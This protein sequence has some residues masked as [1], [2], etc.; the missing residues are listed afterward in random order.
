MPRMGLCSRVLFAGLCVLP[1]GLMAACGGPDFTSGAAPPPSKAAEGGSDR[2]DTPIIL[3]NPVSSQTGDDGGDAAVDGTR[4][5]ATAD[6][7]PVEDATIAL[8]PGDATASTA[9]ADGGKAANADAKNG[10][11][12]DGIAA[13]TA[14]AGCPVG[15]ASCDGGC[16]QLASDPHHCGAC[17][18]DCSRLPNVGSAGLACGAGHCVYQCATDYADCADSGTGC[19]SSLLSVSHCGACGSSCGTTAPAC[20]PTDA[21]SYACTL[22]CPSP[23]T[24]CSGTCADLASDPKNCGGCGMACSPG[25]R[26]SG[27]HC[28]C[29][30]TSGCN[31]CCSSGATCEPYASQSSASCGTG[32]G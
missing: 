19:A 9:A 11:E 27:S 17:G 24:N 30:T 21:G 26:C 18:N 14:D 28:V 10:S 2:D 4:G 6:G 8:A 7:A 3:P 31:G 16:A 13:A 12:V 15:Y 25:T 20:A 22:V 5:D 1:I 23:T 32:G 29:D